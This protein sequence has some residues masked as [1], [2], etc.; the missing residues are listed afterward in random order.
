M[1]FGLLLALPTA[2]A[3]PVCP[4]VGCVYVLPGA[5]GP[6]AGVYAVG[7][8]IQPFGTVWLGRYVLLAGGST[9]CSRL[10]VSADPLTRE[11][12]AV[13]ASAGRT[14]LGHGLDA[15]VDGESQRTILGVSWMSQAD[16][17]C[18]SGVWLGH[19]WPASGW[20]GFGCPAGPAP[21]P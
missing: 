21:L 13:H 8:G 6:G 12:H 15:Q 18:D 9:G 2:A 3:L 5:C 10:Y 4:L 14:P 20:H 11:T 17:T 1:G 7:G 16:G 19:E